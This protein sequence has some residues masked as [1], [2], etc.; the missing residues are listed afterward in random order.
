MTLVVG[1]TNG[2]RLRIISD[3]LVNDP[4]STRR[5]PFDPRMGRPPLNGTLKA[6]IINR[7]QCVCFAGIVDFGHSA[8][9]GL[10]EKRLYLA[11]DDDIVLQHLLQ[12]HLSS[13]GKTDFLLGSLVGES[14]SLSEIRDGRIERDL[15][16][17]WIGH[18]KAFE[19]YQRA[20]HAEARDAAS[21][22]PNDPLRRMELA[23]TQLMF[24]QPV[25]EHGDFFV[26]DF[27]IAVT[28][29]SEG[30]GLTYC[31][32]VCV[33]PAKEVVTSTE[34]E[35]VVPGGRADGGYTYSV[36]APFVVGVPL[37]TVYV[38]TAGFGLV[39]SPLDGPHP[40]EV[41][42]A[43]PEDFIAAVERDFGLR[44]RGIVFDGNVGRRVG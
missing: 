28:A 21:T 8:I 33:L 12:A 39:F 32:G 7:L 38:T 44:P 42:A 14:A 17:A 10:F 5:L 19:Q 37:V 31:T 18:S 4:S 30:Q 36:L 41:I 15:S 20:F 25:D 6:V 2:Q 29:A 35:P 26:G 27:E 3:T 11:G 43:T 9:R 22:G 13:N 34:W 23:F 16:A 1:R 24:E 40:R